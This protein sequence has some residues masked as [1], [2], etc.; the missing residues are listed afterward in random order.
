MH[1]EKKLGFCCALCRYSPDRYQ[2]EPNNRNYHQ[3][4]VLSYR[5]LF[6][7]TI[8]Q[9]FKMLFHVLPKLALDVRQYGTY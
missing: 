1:V 9:F 2:P 5:T 7:K 8:S 3:P 4:L 6:I